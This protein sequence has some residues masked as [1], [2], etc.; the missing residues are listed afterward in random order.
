MNIF[1]AGVHAVGKSYLCA[2]FSKEHAWLHRSASQLIK[3]EIGQ[4]NWSADKRVSDSENNQRALINAVTRINENKQ[5]LLL[6][7]HFVLKGK[8]DEFIRL[9]ADVFSA[10][11]LSG[12]ILIETPAYLIIERLKIRDGVER[13]SDD[14]S[15]FIEVERDQA[16]KVCK[17]LNIPLLILDQPSCEIFTNNALVLSNA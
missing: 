7:G 15:Q 13:K 17:S 4:E 5:R 6:D 11:N 3:E 14:I 12:V 10:L 9:D 1:I 2:D 16:H 8:N